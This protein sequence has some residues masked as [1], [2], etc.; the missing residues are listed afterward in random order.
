M[1][2]YGRNE[3]YTDSVPEVVNP[4]VFNFGKRSPTAHINVKKEDGKGYSVSI[5]YEG[6]TFSKRVEEINDVVTR[7]AL[8]STNYAEK[9]SWPENLQYSLEV[10]MYWENKRDPEHERTVKQLLQTRL[11]GRVSFSEYF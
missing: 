2:D 8:A 7:I 5:T 10:E 3:L 4:D 11:E 9:F 6:T 1:E